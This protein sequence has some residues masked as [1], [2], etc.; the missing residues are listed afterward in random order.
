[1]TDL[2]QSQIKLL[3][4][5]G[6]GHVIAYSRDGDCG[7]LTGTNDILDDKDIWALR[8]KQLIERESDEELDDYGCDHISPNGISCL[9]QLA[10]DEMLVTTLLEGE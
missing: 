8:N 3:R 10:A 4:K 6:E 5:L 9:G 2:T 7:W 1:V